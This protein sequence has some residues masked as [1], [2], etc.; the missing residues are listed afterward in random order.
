MF[1]TDQENFLHLPFWLILEEVERRRLDG[2]LL[3]VGGGEAL[4]ADPLLA[5]VTAAAAF[6]EDPAVCCDDTILDVTHLP[7]SGS[8]S[9]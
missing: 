8:L 3:V 9:L 2:T 7:P 5:T 4:E 6:L 1:N